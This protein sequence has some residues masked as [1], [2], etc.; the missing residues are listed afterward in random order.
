MRLFNRKRPTINDISIPYF[1]WELNLNTKKE[2]QWLNPKQTIALS[3]LYFDVDP[4]IPTIKNE[5]LIRAFYREMAIKSNGGLVECDLIKI[6]SFSAAKTIVKI[7]Q[8]DN[9]TT[10]ITSI[11]IPFNSA[12]FVIRLVANETVNIKNR[13]EFVKR[14]LLRNKIITLQK[15]GYGNWES[16]P[17]QKD[18]SQGT[19]MNKSEEVIYDS[20]FPL[21]PLTQSRKL[22]TTIENEIVF[23]D[24]ILN[25]TSFKK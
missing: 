5:N 1:D 11:T 17:Y 24:T 23:N 13:E 19:L 3:I 7:P 25:L 15:K 18:I 22:I 16:D 10:Y 8:Q 2:K 14:K 9:G 21:H 12:S 6:K 4:D 20:R